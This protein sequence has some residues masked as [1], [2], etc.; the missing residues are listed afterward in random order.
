MRC[1]L[2][3]RRLLL[4]VQALS[5]CSQTFFKKDAVLGNINV[6][7]QFEK[8]ADKHTVFTVRAKLAGTS[9]GTDDDLTRL[10]QEQ[11]NAAWAD[12]QLPDHKASEHSGEL[13][14]YLSWRES[15]LLNTKC[16]ASKKQGLNRDPL[17]CSELKVNKGVCCEALSESQSS[18]SPASTAA[19][20]RCDAQSASAYQQHVTHKLSLHFVP[21]LW[22]EDDVD[23]LNTAL[24]ERAKT[25]DIFQQSTYYDG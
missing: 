2:R 9:I 14:S 1:C 21:L 20:A 22:Q 24:A 18:T 4:Y 19:R 17:L 13:K 15:T 23:A 8:T 10:Q 16:P 3:R 7:V 6:L 25:A 12:S 11:E 5:A